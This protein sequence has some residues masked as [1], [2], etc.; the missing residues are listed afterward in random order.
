MPQTQTAKEHLQALQSKLQSALD[1]QDADAKNTIRAAST[2]IDS[3]KSA[4]TAQLKVDDTKARQ[5]AQEAMD[6]IDTVSQ[7]AEKAMNE[8][9]A[10]LQARVKQM[11]ASAKAALDSTK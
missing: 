10:A 5:Q 11:V 7:N 8:S 6:K 1:K 2:H 4:L 3:A 9:G